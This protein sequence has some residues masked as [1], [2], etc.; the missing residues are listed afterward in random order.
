MRYTR[1]HAARRI[2]AGNAGSRSKSLPKTWK[3]RAAD[4]VGLCC[5]AALVAVYLLLHGTRIIG[6]PAQLVL[7]AAITAAFALL[8]WIAHGVNLS[9]AL[10]G[11]AIAFI[12]STADLRMFWMLL[13]VFALTFAATRA[14]KAR[15]QRL[16]TAESSRGRSA[17][18]VMANLG[19]A[20]LV[21]VIS[22]SAWPLIALAALA[23]AAADTSSSEFGMAFPGKT[24]LLTTW[25]QVPPGTDGGVSLT[26][27]VA[28]LLAAALISVCAVMM[29]IVPVQYA[30]V[31]IYAGFFGSL[32]DSLA[33]ALLERRGLLNNDSVN[34]I[35]TAAAVAIA[36]AML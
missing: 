11:S 25:K 20:A 35:G 29:K 31:L 33:G 28:A 34:L 7:A 17:S 27:T 23:E 24:V 22:A 3:S 9:G 19:V 30:T 18:Q 16:R 10:A 14:G 26:G 13:L 5:A 1:F 2:W 32:L 36:R 6:H 21:V 12:L 8:A 4:T 15:K